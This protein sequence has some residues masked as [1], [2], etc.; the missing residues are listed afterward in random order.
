MT[1]TVITAPSMGIAANHQQV[2]EPIAKPNWGTPLSTA[3]KGYQARR[4]QVIETDLWPNGPPVGLH[5]SDRN[6]LLA[7]RF[8]ANGWD[9]ISDRHLQRLHGGR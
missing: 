2:I 3:A 7:Q 4:L 8:A 5:V 6:R 9:P 1:D